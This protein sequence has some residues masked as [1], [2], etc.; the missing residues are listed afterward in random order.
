MFG[1]VGGRSARGWRGDAPADDELQAAHE[2]NVKIL[3][4][5]ECFVRR[6]RD[7]WGL[8]RLCHVLTT[9]TKSS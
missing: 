5:G 6:R 8:E 9:T 2:F 7:K 1:I 3:R 4:C